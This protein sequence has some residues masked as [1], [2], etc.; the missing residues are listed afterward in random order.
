MAKTSPKP[1]TNEIA[2]IQADAEVWSVFGKWMGNPDPV[3][4]LKGGGK[5]IKLYDEVWRDPHCRSVLGTRADVV[6]GAEWELKPGDATDQAAKIAE[7]VKLILEGSGLSRLVKKLM[8]AVLYGFYAA[9]ILWTTENGYTVPRFISKHPRRF[10]FSPERELRLLTKTAPFDGATV[11]E[12]KFIVFSWGDDDNPYGE[13]LGQV[14]WWNVWFKKVGIKFWLKCLEK[15]GQPTVVGEYP[16]CDENAKTKLLD[17]M[18]AIQTATNIAIPSG[19]VLKLLEATRAGNVEYGPL[20]DV[21]D[22]SSSKAVLGQTGTTEMKGEGGLGSSNKVHDEV[23]LD[24]AKGDGDEL[25]EVL[26]STLVRWIVDFNWGTDAPAPKLWFRTEPEPDL[27]AQI[28]IDKIL[29]NDICLPLSEGYF[30]DAY[31]R[32]RP[33]KEESIV[34]V[35]GV[36]NRIYEYHLTSGVATPNESRTQLGLPPIPGGDKMLPV[37]APAPA[38]FADSVDDFAE[39]PEFDLAQKAQKGADTASDWAVKN[40]IQPFEQWAG[41]VTDAVTAAPSLPLA[42]VAVGGLALTPDRVADVLARAMKAADAAGAG[43]VLGAGGGS[44]LWGVGTPFKDALEYFQDQAF[45]IAKVS[46]QDLLDAVKAEIE[47]AIKNGATLAD[48]AAKM[49]DLFSR[50]GYTALKPHRVEVIYRTNVQGAFNNGRLR[51]MASPA[52]TA[53]RPYWKYHAVGDLAT[54]PEHAAMNGRIYPYNDPVWRRMYPYKGE[55]WQWFNCRCLVTTVSES[56]MKR[57][58]LTLS[59]TEG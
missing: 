41:V 31:S 54:R 26:S 30:Y 44:T 45:T 55:P 51:Q 25:G 18:D 32:P 8:K 17:A 34:S 22:R 20:V 12:R 50:H 42:A 5:G 1:D 57:D 49:P 59:K 43:S 37:Q 13:G 33:Q 28:E 35:G 6:A 19:T 3:V 10:A 24:I 16:S 40:G 15:F 9:E 7:E 47:D 4:Q 52:V 36:Q 11:P 56:E 48:F 39:D 58:G 38:A 14:L 23:R 29:K 27:S 46:A 53:A 2:T 21:M